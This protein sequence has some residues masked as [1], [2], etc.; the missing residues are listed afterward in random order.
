MAV[1]YRRVVGVFG[2]ILVSLGLRPEEK[3]KAKEFEDWKD[4]QW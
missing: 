1:I 2:G 4:N 3:P